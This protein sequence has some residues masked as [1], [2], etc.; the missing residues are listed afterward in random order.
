MLGEWYAHWFDFR[1]FY[2]SDF[3]FFTWSIWSSWLRL[4]LV[5]NNIA[6]Y[7]HRSLAIYVADNLNRYTEKS[8]SREETLV[9]TEVLFDELL[10]RLE[11]IAPIGL[12]NRHIQIIR[13]DRIEISRWIG[14]NIGFIH[15][16][17]QS[18]G[19]TLFA[20]KMKEDVEAAQKLVPE[21]AEGKPVHDCENTFALLIASMKLIFQ[22]EVVK[23]HKFGFAF[24]MSCLFSRSRYENRN[25]D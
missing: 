18:C 2:A 17:E 14:S 24:V 23:S 6:E 12:N 25:I 9:L 1:H 8:L 4:P 16:F 19:K 20:Q 11:E 22:R 10:V 21:L 13:D 5:Q 15:Q 7:F 3:N